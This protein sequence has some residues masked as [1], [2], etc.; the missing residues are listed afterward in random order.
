MPTPVDLVR[1]CL[2][3]AA[4]RVLD[5]A[6]VVARRRSHAQTTSLHVVSALLALPSS[7]LRDACARA[8]S[9]PYNS[10]LQF[11]ALELC[12][13]VSLDRLQSSKS[14]ER[15]PISNSLSAAIKRGQASQRRNPENYHLQ[16]IHCNQ[17]TPSLLKVE[18]KYFVLSILDDPIVN[19]VFGEAGFQSFEIKRAI[20]QP[21]VAQLSSKFLRTPRCPPIF[22]GNLTDSGLGLDPVRA[23]PSLP[24]GFE[25]VDESCRRIGEVLLKRNEKN[26]KNPL[27]V[28]DYAS[29]ALRGF[30]KNVTSRKPGVLPKEVYGVD[31]VCIEEEISEFVLENGSEERMPS[32]FKELETTVEQCSGPG[33]VVNFGEL[34]ALVG[35]NVSSEAVKFVVSKL[36]SLLEMNSRNLWLIGA[37]ANYEAYSK[38]SNMFPSIEKDWDLQLLPIHFKSSLMGSFV[39]FGGFFSLPLDP[40]NPMRSKNQHSPCY[41]CTEKFEHEVAA[42]LKERS[43]TSVADRCSEK[44]PSWLERAELDTRKGVDM[45]KNVP[46]HSV[47]AKEDGTALH[48]EVLELQKKWN[49]TCR[50]HH[51]QVLPKLDTPETR[52]QVPIP[53][54]FQFIADKK[55]SSIKDP[56]S[57]ENLCANPNLSMQID[58]RKVLPT[59]PNTSIASTSQAAYVNSQSRVQVNFSKDQQ[60]QI[61]N[62]GHPLPP[63]PPSNPTNPP[64]NPPTSSP[65]AVTT[66]LGLG[67]IYASIRQA[68]E[69]PELKYQSLSPPK[70]PKFDAVC[71]GNSQHFAKHGSRSGG[72]I[73]KLGEL[74]HDGDDKTLR[75]ILAEKVGRQDEAIITITQAVSRCRNGHGRHRGSSGRGDIWFTFLGPDRA[76]KKLIASTLAEI[77][78]GDQ[79]NIIC[80]D[81]SSQDRGSRPENIF[82][83]QQL[84]GCDMEFRG[85]YVDYIAEE[86]RK[87]PDSVVF[88][89]NVEKADPVTQNA[90]SEA[91]K[92]GKFHDSFRRVVSISTVIFVTT[93][94]IM[95][96][97]DN[98]FSERKAGRFSEEIIFGA[99]KWQMQLSIS[100][101]SKDVSRPHELKANVTP[102]KKTPKAESRNKRKFID[103]D[104]SSAELQERSHKSIRSNLDLNLP[105]EEAEEEINS[106]DYD[107][108][109]I[110]ESTE[111]W[112]EDF[113]DQ[114]DAKVYF[115]PLNFD[116]I[117]AKLTRD[118]Y[119]RF[120][121]AMGSEVVLEID[122]EV[123]IEILAATWLSN[124]K[125]AIEF[126]IEDVLSRHFVQFQQKYHPKPGSVVKLAVCDGRPF[127]LESSEI[128]LPIKINM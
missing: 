113:C 21:P 127:E 50:L 80:M 49:D 35:D 29:K 70:S 110:S 60:Q 6:V 48:A 120:Q 18:L 30:I 66:D 124:K 81:F 98:E 76:G 85:H 114:V 28:G 1:Q 68:A 97:N 106:I 31:V 99:K 23:G 54:V 53:E 112:L 103:N 126:W 94:T 123:M 36:T 88:L 27:L 45:A 69:T 89:E 7:I 12:V 42:I 43:I 86:L 52:S 100:W 8:R 51:P 9:I 65:I 13:G 93:S 83:C 34:K 11:R 92:I 96:G 39:P 40:K 105:I 58:L 71:E 115:K 10:R 95:Q 64:H 73:S 15:P 108:D 2:T 122:D 55:E 72:S 74:A 25:D 82:Q 116:L 121:R 41:L 33:V 47:Q 102:S 79:E 87:K 107:S 37:A 16:Q 5:E 117:A 3:E 67:T 38:F 44:L 22:L 90:L 59:I 104:D 32:R 101:H 128:C 77:I 24:F 56:A 26:G 19:R 63:H 78:F 111:A 125:M 61:E 91:V 109:A 75:K 119:I 4:A 20:L 62:E 118:I 46:H 84:D 57:K 14:V 17:Q